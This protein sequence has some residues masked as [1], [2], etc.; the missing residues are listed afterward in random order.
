MVFSPKKLVATNTP[1]MTWL[2]ASSG[3]V[4]IAASAAL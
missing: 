1:W 3:R 4:G 2:V